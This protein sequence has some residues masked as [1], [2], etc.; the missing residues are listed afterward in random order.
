MRK[1]FVLALASLFV[2][3]LT[4]PALSA[5]KGLAKA[6][7]AFVKNAANGGMMEVQM[8][9]LATKNAASQEVK[10]FGQMMVTDHGKAND[11]L[12]SLAAAKELKLPTELK[13]MQKAKVDKLSKET[14]AEFDKKY[15][16]AMV[17]DHKK[18]VEKFQKATKDV[19]DPEI[20]AWAAKTLPT[21]EKHLQRAKEVAQKVGA[22]K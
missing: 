5:D 12:K 18:H 2:I 11:E 9:Q 16:K 17:K 19:K 1:G 7:K 20:N 13:G 4:M 8:G 3:C 6:D 22:V 21:L 15:M 14:G 10:D